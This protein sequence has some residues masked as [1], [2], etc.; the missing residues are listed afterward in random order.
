MDAAGI[1]SLRRLSEAA[2]IA[3]TGAT[4]VVHGDSLPN[5][6]TVSALASALRVPASKIYELTH[7]QD[8]TARPWSPPAEVQRLTR[9]EQDAISEMIRSMAAARDPEEVGD[10]EQRSAPMNSAGEWLSTRHAKRDDA[11]SYGLAAHPEDP[12]IGGD[13]LPEDGP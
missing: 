13:Q 2:G 9:R 1:S 5:D 11:A 8:I 7:G 10:H 12:D 3:H 4:R 6:E